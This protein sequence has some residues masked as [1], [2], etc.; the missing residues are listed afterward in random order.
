MEK[1]SSDGDES[2]GSVT[3]YSDEEATNAPLLPHM[4][5]TSSPHKGTARKTEAAFVPSLEG[6]RGVA[7][8]IVLFS[9]LWA[10][11]D[12]FTWVLGM[13]GVTTFF[14]L[15][16]YLIT[17][18]L[19]KMQST[20]ITYRHLP[21]F[22]ASRTVR[23]APSLF[24]CVFGTVVIWIHQ[25]RSFENIKEHV[26]TVLLYVENMFCKDI[27]HDNQVRQIEKTTKS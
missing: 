17:G 23:L 15:S 11:C 10:P 21:L 20:G 7:I 22:F 5:S 18:I 1:I 13:M 16:G 26:I 12:Q 6:L 19:V 25:G 3:L 2:V 8:I 27:K 4:T 24:L 14:S 9:H